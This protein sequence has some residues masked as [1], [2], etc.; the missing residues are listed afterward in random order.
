MMSVD[1]TASLTGLPESLVVSC[2][3]VFMLLT[4]ASLAALQ[5]NI[6]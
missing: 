2:C 3:D 4:A 1:S 5:A 6:G